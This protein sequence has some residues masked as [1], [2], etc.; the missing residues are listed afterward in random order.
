MPNN[1]VNK[2][3]EVCGISKAKA[4]EL[5]TQAEEI[6]KKQYKLGNELKGKDYQIVTGIFKKS[7][8][9]DCSRKLGWLKEDMNT[10]NDDVLLI[11]ELM[12]RCGGKSKKKLKVIKEE[13]LLLEAK[14]KKEKEKEKKDTKKEKEIKKNITSYNEELPE[15]EELEKDAK[16]T[17]TTDKIIKEVIELIEEVRKPRIRI[18]KGPGGWEGMKQNF[19]EL[20]KLFTGKNLAKRAAILAGTGSLGYLAYKN[21]D[22]LKDKF[23]KASGIEDKNNQIKNLTDQLAKSNT[24][25]EIKKKWLKP[26]LAAAV[27][28]G[29]LLGGGTVA[30]LSNKKESQN[31][32]EV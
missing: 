13:D 25:T 2:A 23:D 14:K 29:A 17:E 15:E 9:N 7:I 26:Q 31:K 5:W 27:G 11:T 30:A 8:T 19:G 1:L 10:I 4:E 32:K 28:G 6:A 16:E 12:K 24:A 22:Y 18:E 20:G 21:K 3:V